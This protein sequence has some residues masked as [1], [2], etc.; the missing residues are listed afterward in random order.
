MSSATHADPRVRAG[1]GSRASVGRL[2]ASASSA[3][4]SRVSSLSESGADAVGRTLAIRAAAS[5]RS[6]RR[7]RTRAVC[8]RADAAPQVRPCSPSSSTSR[9]PRA[10]KDRPLRSRS[11]SAARATPSARTRHASAPA[12]TNRCRA[13]R[14]TARAALGS[15]CCNVRASVNSASPRRWCDR[16]SPNTRA[17]LRRAAWPSRT[18]PA[19]MSTSARS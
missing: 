5:A 10:T 3:R 4:T 1:S 11:T 16:R 7:S 6:P 2:R 12:R 13:A 15:V 9:S 19:A 18:S 14:A 8:R 17:A